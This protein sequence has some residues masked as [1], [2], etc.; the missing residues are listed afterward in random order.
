MPGRWTCPECGRRFGRA[1]QSHTCDPASSVESYLSG[2]PEERHATYRAALAVIRE[3]GDVDI[4]PV[5]VG[6]MVKRARTF[7]EL[8]P[9]RGAVELSFKM[10]RELGSPRVR[11]TLAS[12]THRR[13]HFVDLR[14]PEDVDDEVRRWLAEAYLDSPA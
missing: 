10:S 13:V 1:N 2:Q 8:R 9:R 12:S 6:I 5:S 4:D 3:L 14:T 11:K 7:C